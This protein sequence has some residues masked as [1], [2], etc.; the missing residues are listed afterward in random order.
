MFTMVIGAGRANPQNKTTAWE[1][2]GEHI[3]GRK[4]RLDCRGEMQLGA[5]NE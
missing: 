1:K 5:G 4:A 3:S 2:N